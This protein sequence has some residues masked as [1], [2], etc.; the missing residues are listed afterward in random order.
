MAAPILDVAVIGGSFAGNSAALMLARGRRSVAVFDTGLPRNSPAAAGNGFLGMDGLDPKGIQSRAQADVLKYPTTQIRPERVKAIARTDDGFTVITVT[1]GASSVNAR[2]IVLA[3]GKTDIL[4]DI[5]GLSGRWGNSVLQC[6]YCHG[7]EVA[8]RPTGLLI[9]GPPSWH[10]ARLLSD[11]T[12]DLIVFTNGQPIPD[13]ELPALEARNIRIVHDRIDHM[14]ADGTL[15]LIS[16]APVPRDVLYL[17]THTKLAS[18][19]AAD[20]GCDLTDGPC[21]PMVAVDDFGATSVPGVYAAGDITRPFYGATMAAASGALA[22]T[23]CHQ[24]LATPDIPIKRAA[25]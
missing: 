19:L 23:A 18:P 2:R 22:G 24:S 15:H 6:P 10:Q 4:P 17:T 13:A 14:D 21:G 3:F 1:T 9:S 5:P 7:Y 12:S 20:L 25:A 11:W 16:A 8:D